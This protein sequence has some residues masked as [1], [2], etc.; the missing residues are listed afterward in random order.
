[1]GRWRLLIFASAP[2][3][4]AIKSAQWSPLLYAALLLPW[5]SPLA[6]CKPTLGAPVL[7]WRRSSL[8]WL[9]AALLVLLSLLLMPSWPWRWLA[10]T[11]DYGGFVPL[12]SLPLGPGLLLA[13]LRWRDERARWLLLLACV[14]QHVLFYDQLLVLAVARSR[15]ELLW[16]VLC[17]WVGLL[18]ALTAWH[19]LLT[20][21]TQHV[22]LTCCYLPALMVVLRPTPIHRIDRTSYRSS[23]R[24]RHSRRRTPHE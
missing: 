16:L 5:L 13:L 20:P 1:M 15:G 6:V 11:G 4:M 18:G 21:W 14:P 2:M 23:S 7:L 12:L 19:T 17:G 8:A 10:Q 9:D 22:I 24:S 3:L